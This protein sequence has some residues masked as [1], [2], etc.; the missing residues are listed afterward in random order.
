[1]LLPEL[2]FCI[3]ISTIPHNEPCVKT[4]LRQEMWTGPFRVIGKLPNG[5]IKL[6]IGKKSPYIVHPNRVK[7][8][9]KEILDFK[10]EKKTKNNN[11]KRVSFSGID[12]IIYPTTY[13]PIKTRN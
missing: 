9:E 4:K 2:P 6:N 5:N 3:Y 10:E 11:K 8:A 13:S 7:L 12:E 1:V